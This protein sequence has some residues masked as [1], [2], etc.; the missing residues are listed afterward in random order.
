MFRRCRRRRRLTGTTQTPPTSP[1][2]HAS[3]QPIFTFSSSPVPPSSSLSAQGP[4]VVHDLRPPHKPTQSTTHKALKHPSHSHILTN[5]WPALV[6]S[7]TSPTYYLGPSSTGYHS[8]IHTTF[9]HQCNS[10]VNISL[11]RHFGTAATPLTTTP[12]TTGAALRCQRRQQVY[13]A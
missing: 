7:N 8:H 2:Y 9:L 5:L 12:T 11:H 1:K 10:P 6:D 3:I 13:S 4:S